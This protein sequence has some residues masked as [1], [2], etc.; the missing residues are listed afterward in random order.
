MASEI[1][2]ILERALAWLEAKRC[3]RSHCDVVVHSPVSSVRWAVEFAEDC[4]LFHGYARRPTVVVAA[5]DVIWAFEDIQD[6][7]RDAFVRERSWASQRWPL[8][9]TFTRM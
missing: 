4:E 1:V 2:P 3:V 5:I 7:A 8:A 6:Y 9:Q